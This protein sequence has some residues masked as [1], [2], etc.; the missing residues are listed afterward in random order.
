M[1]GFNSPWLTSS[2]TQI[3]FYFVS[4][5][6]VLKACARFLY[7]YHSSFFANIRPPR[8][9]SAL[10]P[11]APIIKMKPSWREHTF[12]MSFWYLPTFSWKMAGLRGRPVPVC[13]R[14]GGLDW[15]VG[16]SEDFKPRVNGWVRE[17]VKR[18]KLQGGQRRGRAGQGLDFPWKH[19]KASAFLQKAAMALSLTPLR[20]VRVCSRCVAERI[21]HPR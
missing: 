11:G 21:S 18:E 5:R 4:F 19:N 7:I 13:R 12:G 1:F 6:F 8:G 2:Q 9:F 17:R 3:S 10:R 16:W 14:T 20:S 15:R